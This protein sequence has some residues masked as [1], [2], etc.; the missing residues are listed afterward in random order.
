MK[1][2]FCGALCL[3]LLFST[4]HAENKVDAIAKSKEDAKFDHKKFIFEE[5]PKIA[6]F[7]KEYVKGKIDPED[8]KVCDAQVEKIKEV[9]PKIL[10]SLAKITPA[11]TEVCIK[12]MG[13]ANKVGRI[14]RGVPAIA[15]K[16][17]PSLRAQ[18]KEIVKIIDNPDVDEENFKKL[19]DLLEK[20]TK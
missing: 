10:R 7:V 4:A 1:T 9:S 16:L 13:Q 3:A 15:R 5:A 14:A 20:V 6:G 17:I 11:A 8:K 18:A 2:L 19:L 12:K